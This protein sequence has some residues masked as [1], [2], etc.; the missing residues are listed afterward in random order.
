MRLKR[1]V[2]RGNGEMNAQGIAGSERRREDFR[3]LTGAG[4]FAQ[5]TVWSIQNSWV[6]GSP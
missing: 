5:D 3:L 6:C 4:N 1:A 2:N